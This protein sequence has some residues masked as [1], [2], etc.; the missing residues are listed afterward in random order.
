MF[1]T[2]MKSKVFQ[3]FTEVQVED[4]YD[5]PETGGVFQIPYFYTKHLIFWVLK[6]IHTG[7]FAKM[8][9]TVSAL[10]NVCNDWHLKPSTN[11]V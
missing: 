9:S 2:E 8:Q 11:D 3:N 5:S 4:N 7:R 6:C 1:S 10:K